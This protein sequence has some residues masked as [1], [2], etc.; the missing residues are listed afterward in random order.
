MN[1]LAHAL[2]SGTHEP[3]I[4][5]NFI[6]DHVK[7]KPDS[8]FSPEI[9]RGIELHRFID[10][11]TDKHPVVRQSVGRLKPKYARYSPVIVDMF[12]DHL[13]AKHWK[14]YSDIP[15]RKFTYGVYKVVLGYYLI[16]PAKTKRILP[17]MIADDWLAGYSRLSGL[18]QALQGMARRTSF[19]SGMETAVHD[20]QMDYHLFLEEFNTF[21]PEL[22]KNVDE[23]LATWPPLPAETPK[24]I[25]AVNKAYIRM[26]TAIKRQ[27]QMNRPPFTRG[28]K[29]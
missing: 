18:A 3:I 24:R 20:L 19:T 11:F 13:L 1:F 26:N 4:V 7:G 15:L 27:M 29:T 12:Y 28:K 14:T 6:A 17:F 21:Y 22:Q 23:I 8:R 5:G 25:S 16:L 10:D 2:L 9:L